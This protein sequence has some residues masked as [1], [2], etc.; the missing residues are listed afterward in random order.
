M[1]SIRLDNYFIF[2]NIIFFFFFFNYLR[3]LVLLLT[4]ETLLIRLSISIICFV[5]LLRFYPQISCQIHKANREF[6]RNLLIYLFL[7]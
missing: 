3:M 7:I 4:L 2:I 6:G 1:I 5:I